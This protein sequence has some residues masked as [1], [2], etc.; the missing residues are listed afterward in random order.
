[1]NKKSALL[2]LVAAIFACI[3]AMAETI[4]PSNKYISRKIASSDFTAIRTNTAIDIEYAVGTKSVELYAPDNLIDYIEV[5]V[6]DDELRIG[7]KDNMNINGNHNTVL[8]VK[9]PNVTGF[10]TSSAGS[11]SINSPIR[12]KNTK[13]TLA[14]NSAGDIKA[15]NIEANELNLTTNSAGTISVGEIKAESVTVKVNSAGNISTGIIAARQ[16]AEIYTNSAGDV[17][18]PEIIAGTSVGVRANSAG[19][20]Q[21][22]AIN[23]EST[24]LQ[25]NSTGSIVAK[26]IK[27][28]TVKARAN[29]MG[30]VTIAGNCD[31]AEL[32]AYSLG[33]VDA[34]GLRANHV[35]ASARSK[36]NITC[37]ALQ[38]LDASRFG[39]GKIEYSGNPAT[40]TINDYKGGGITKR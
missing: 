28:K 40:V 3:G 1:M 32:G 15:G 29:S 22:G 27:A 23:T 19:D 12:Q 2:L 18:I 38:S 14:V 20:I 33:E 16:M 26:S 5:R 35:T 10:T 6:I 34:S 8:K 17:K 24:S 13:V 25:S 11:I 21:I 9:A 4:T 37:H 39:I 31:S 7:Y 30:N 36:G